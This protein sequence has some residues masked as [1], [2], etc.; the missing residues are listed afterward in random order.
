M[1]KQPLHL[2]VT[3]HLQILHT[4]FLLHEW[5]S[6]RLISQMAVADQRH[7]HSLYGILTHILSKQFPAMQMFLIKPQGVSYGPR[8]GNPN[9]TGGHAPNTS[10]G[11]D[12]IADMKKRKFPDFI[13]CKGHESATNDTIL[14]IIEVKKED[15]QGAAPWTQL[16]EY[17][18][19]TTRL[20]NTVGRL[21]GLFIAGEK[22]TRFSLN[23]ARLKLDPRCGEEVV[24]L[25]TCNVLDATFLEWLARVSIRYWPR[26]R[27]DVWNQFDYKSPLDAHIPHDPFDP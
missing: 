17:M 18:Y 5:E 3:H 2:I 4:H 13:I 23:V 8:A 1:R 15:D 9:L 7:E 12:F 26:R 19:R 6:K 14:S 11:G 24:E 16:Y 27:I 20:A 10:Y 21:I 25:D 22:V